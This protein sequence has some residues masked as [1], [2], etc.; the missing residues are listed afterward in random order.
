[1]FLLFEIYNITRMTKFV[2]QMKF[3]QIKQTDK[4]TLS[5]VE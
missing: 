4:R 2:G 5:D 1:M 3:Q